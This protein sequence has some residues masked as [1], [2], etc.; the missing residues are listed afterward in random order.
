MAIVKNT[1][2]SVSDRFGRYV[3]GGET[4]VLQTRLGWWERTVIEQDDDDIT[5]IIE[6]GEEGRAD[7]IAFRIYQKPQLQWLVLQYNNIIDTVEQLKT[8]TVL[9]LPTQER[10]MLDIITKQPQK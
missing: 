4:T 5:Y 8:G 1:P 9:R 10:V 7:L 6:Q 3:Q 2:T